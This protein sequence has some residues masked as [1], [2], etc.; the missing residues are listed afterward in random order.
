MKKEGVMKKEGGRG[1]DSSRRR[2][3]RGGEKEMRGRW[4]SGRMADRQRGTV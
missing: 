1:L 4:E 2:K 3:R